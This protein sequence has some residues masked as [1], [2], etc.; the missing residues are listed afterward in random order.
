MAGQ[1][2]TP[3]RISG[4]NNRPACAADKLKANVLEGWKRELVDRINIYDGSN[5]K[6][7]RT[8]VPSRARCNFNTNIKGAF[9]GWTPESGKEKESY[10]VLVSVMV[11]HIN[12]Q[13]SHPPLYSSKDSR[14]W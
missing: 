4:A 6:F 7:I 1:P 9:A 2:G 14:L 11:P 3:A 12:S 8:F 10:G 13:A 5:E